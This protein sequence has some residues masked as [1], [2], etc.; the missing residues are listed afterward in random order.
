VDHGTGFELK[1]CL[2]NDDRAACTDE[3]N[4]WQ[5]GAYELLDCSLGLHDLVE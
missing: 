5:S 4:K 1:L 2:V 3:H